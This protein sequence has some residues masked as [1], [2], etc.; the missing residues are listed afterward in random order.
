[1][2]ELNLAG[3]LSA[4]SSSLYA[5]NLLAFLS[6]FMDEETEKKWPLT[7]KMSWSSARL[8]A[9]MARLFTNGSKMREESDDDT[10]NLD[11]T[12]WGV[13]CAPH[14]G[15]LA[16]PS[17]LAAWRERSAPLSIFFPSS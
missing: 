17:L 1:M 15:V 6:P 3:E 13:D 14:F 7:G 16:P 9:A 10:C 5:R 2:G 11:E 4:N 12:N 8:F